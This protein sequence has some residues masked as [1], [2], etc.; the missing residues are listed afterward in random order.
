MKITIEQA[1][2]LDSILKNIL[3][4]KIFVRSI[5]EIQ[6]NLLPDE[7]KD[8]CID[9]YSILEN[10]SARLLADNSQDDNIR[11]SDNTE[12]FL[13]NGGFTKLYIDG[14][15][16]Q[17]KQEKNESLEEEKLTFDTGN[18]KRTFKN[19]WFVI[20]LSIASFILLLFKFLYD[21]LVKK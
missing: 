6:S 19:Y 10:H 2:H 15:A 16:K 5:D 12:A 14:E 11:S 21:I 18:S 3:D 9:L 13:Y 8:Y 4:K 20:G 17:K 1:A 7:T